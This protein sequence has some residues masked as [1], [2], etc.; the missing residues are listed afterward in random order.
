M[1]RVE[2]GDR[3]IGRSLPAERGDDDGGVP[4]STL[5]SRP[6]PSVGLQ[7][8]TNGQS[9]EPYIRRFVVDGRPRL[10]AP[11]HFESSREGPTKGSVASLDDEFGIESFATT[12]RGEI[13]Q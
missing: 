10:P 13:V 11:P 8:A 9:V 12:M 2:G 1:C 4:S 7:G 3:K 5:D 6:Y